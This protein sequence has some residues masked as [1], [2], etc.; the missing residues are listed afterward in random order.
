MTGA[1]SRS[2]GNRYER[3]VAEYLRGHG[4]PHAATTRAVL[5]HGGTRQPGDV[6]GPVGV[7]IE[8]KAVTAA[9]WPSW[10]AQ[11]ARQAGTLVP[12]V[13]RKLPGVADVGQHP[14]VLPYG[15]YVERLDGVPATVRRSSRTCHAELWLSR[16]DHDRIE[17]FDGR[18]SWA[19]V[20]FCELCRAARTDA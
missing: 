9:A 6:V 7:A 3:A 2:K 11:A 19:V 13:V 17:W 14:T 20:R 18:R 8:C 15:D 10:L 1:A 4:Y 12:V 5:G 16:P